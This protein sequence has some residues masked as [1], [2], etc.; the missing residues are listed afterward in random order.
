MLS[1]LLRMH[2]N[3]NCLQHASGKNESRLHGEQLVY[4][5]VLMKIYELQYWYLLISILICVEFHAEKQNKWFTIDGKYYE[6]FFNQ[7]RIYSMQFSS[8]PWPK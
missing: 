2:Y 6:V 7:V 3:Y 4:N 8:G 1:L 5:S